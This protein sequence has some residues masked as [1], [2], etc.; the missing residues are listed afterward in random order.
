LQQGLI[1]KTTGEYVARSGKKMNIVEAIQSGYIVIV[2]APGVSRNPPDSIPIQAA[3]AKKPSAAKPVNGS[4]PTGRRPS[5]PKPPPKPD[6]K[7]K[8][9]DKKS[10]SDDADFLSVRGGTIRARIIESGV[11]TT[12]I[13]SFMVE[14]PATGEEITLEE[15]VKRGLV[16]EET[17]AM[18]KQE[19]TTDSTVDR[20]V[21]LITDPETGIEMPSEEAVA[22]GIVTQV[23]IL[24][25][26]TGISEM[27][28][29]EKVFATGR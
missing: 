22:K 29:S 12:K 5:A 3:G 8:P 1:S 9:S 11:T 2:G 16:S 15:A 17:A 19:V 20:V 13:S 7:K 14:V 10:M 18:Y 28:C 24:L 26:S 25:L 4:S 23:S 6:S 21:V 27:Y